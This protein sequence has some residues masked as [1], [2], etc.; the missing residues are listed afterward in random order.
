MIMGAHRLRLVRNTLGKLEDLIC[1]LVDET[2]R[3]VEEGLQ[4]VTG[5]KADGH[6]EKP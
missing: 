6:R 5:W 3:M 4:I 1:T 2:G